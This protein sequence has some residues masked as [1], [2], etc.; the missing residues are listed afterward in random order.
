VEVSGQ[1]HDPAAGNN[2]TGGWIGPRESFT[3][4][5]SFADRC[6]LAKCKWLFDRS[7]THLDSLSK[8]NLHWSPFCSRR[9]DSH[10]KSLHIVFSVVYFSLSYV[11]FTIALFIQS[12]TYWHFVRFMA[13]SLIYSRPDA[14][15][16]LCFG[17]SL[18]VQCPIEIKCYTYLFLFFCCCY[19]IWYTSWATSTRIAG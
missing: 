16:I 14:L 10:I 3:W 13:E 19:L 15:E 2:W 8:H 7:V 4:A 12:V 5:F 18:R 11:I 6:R 1:L 17:S 9:H